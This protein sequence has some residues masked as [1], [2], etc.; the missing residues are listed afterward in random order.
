VTDAVVNRGALATPWGATVITPAATTAAANPATREERTKRGVQQEQVGF[1]EFTG[2][3]QQMGD[4]A[5]GRQQLIGAR[6]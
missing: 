5:V 2:L 1:C 4:R 6:I 3:H